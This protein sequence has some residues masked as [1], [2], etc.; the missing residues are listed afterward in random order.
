M[1]ALD[2]RLGCCAGVFSGSF[3]RIAH[4]CDRRMYPT[5]NQSVD[6]FP[7]YGTVPVAPFA[8]ALPQNAF[9]TTRF[10]DDYVAS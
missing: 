2:A 1:G 4:G 9:G 3:R 8:G 10:S 5:V 7:G 6:L